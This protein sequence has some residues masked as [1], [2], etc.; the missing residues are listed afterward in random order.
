MQAK[1]KRIATILVAAAAMAHSTSADAADLPR[2]G[3]NIL[4]WPRMTSPVFGCLLEKT[5]GHRDPR[6]NCGLKSVE[7]GDPCT[8]T[9]NYYAG[10]KFPPALAARIHPLAS[11][12]SLEFEHGKMQ[13]VTVTLTG[14]FSEGDVR[15][16]FGLS[17][18]RGSP[19]NILSVSVQDCSLVST[20][21][22]LTGFDHMG[23]GECRLLE[24]GTRK[25]ISA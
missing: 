13:A 23:A 22:L 6:F 12:V 15:R 10:P 2:A 8:D 11:T 5:F 16:A 21:L 4:G 17:D 20:C 19:G 24:A 1:F 3:M 18:D 14:K 9:D 25:M 7:T